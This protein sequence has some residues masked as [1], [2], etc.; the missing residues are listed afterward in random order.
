[1]SK[2][3]TF[4]GTKGNGKN[5]RHLAWFTIGA[6]IGLAIGRSIPE[7]FLPFMGR[8]FSDGLLVQFAV[9]AFISFCLGNLGYDRSTLGTTRRS[10]IWIRATGGLM[11]GIGFPLL[12]C[13]IQ[14]GAL[15]S[16]Q[17]FIKRRGM[18]FEFTCLFI[19]GI[20]SSLSTEF[21][22]RAI[23]PRKYMNARRIG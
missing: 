22:I 10:H 4:V 14:Y 19:I 11:L 17:V 21:T 8:F 2:H 12:Y 1:M 6:V 20:A 3:D 16:V 7:G 23:R 15:D 5:P 18:F 9:F 13:V